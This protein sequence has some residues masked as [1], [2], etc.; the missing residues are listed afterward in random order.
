MNFEEYIELFNSHQIKFSSIL[1][2]IETY[3]SIH[4][5]YNL[6]KNDIRRIDYLHLR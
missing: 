4:L 2:S 5:F 1:L 6:K 3:R